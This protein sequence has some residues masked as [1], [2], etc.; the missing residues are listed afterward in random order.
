MSHVREIIK[1]HLNDEAIDHMLGLSGTASCQFIV[2]SFPA[3]LE[4]TPSHTIRPLHASFRD[5]LI[6]KRRSEGKPWSLTPIDPEYLLTE[7]CFRIM[8]NQLRFNICGITTSYEWNNDY[9]TG[10]NSK[11]AISRE[12]KYACQHWAG[13]LQAIQNLDS[14]IMTLLHNFSYAH[15]MFWAEVMS[16]HGLNSEARD[17]C[18]AVAD[19]IKVSS[20]LSLRYGL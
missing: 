16:V 1:P 14:S 19:S 7:C 20:V 4:Y 18:N 17:A 3:L 8:E 10:S 9:F 2:S 15:F 5:Y 12:L 6:D 11:A 13:H